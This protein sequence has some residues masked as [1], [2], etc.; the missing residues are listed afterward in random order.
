MYWEELVLNKFDKF[1]FK[2]YVFD[3][4]TN[5]VEL[6]YSLDNEIDFTEVISWNIE[7]VSY[8]PEILERA[9]FALWIMAG[10]SYYK[11]YL[12]KEIVIERGGLTESQ[13]I[14]FSKTYQLG[15]AQFFYTNQL[16]WEGVINFKSD[17][18]ESKN[19]LSTGNSGSLSA[20][21]GGKDSIVAA[22]LMNLMGIEFDCWAVNQAERFV[23]ISESIGAKTFSV[24]RRLDGKLAKLNGVDAYNGHVPI[25]AINSFIGVVLAILAG[26]KSIVWAI[27]SST[28]EPNTSWKGLAVNHQYSKS[29]EFEVDIIEYINTNIASDLEYYS[30]LRPISELRIAEIFCKKFFEKYKTKFSSCNA[31]FNI[32]NNSS[33]KWCGKCPKCAFIFII[34][35]PF[36]EKNKLLELF[37]G[38]DIYSDPDMKGVIEELL[39][40]DGHKPLECVGEIAEVRQ[41]VQMAKNSGH[42]PEAEQ[43]EFDEPNYNYLKYSKNSI[44]SNLEEKLKGILDSI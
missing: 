5:T 29:S 32:G 20:L 28:D 18:V 44:P 37:N 12:P 42:Y 27:E 15:L 22:E 30:I 4:A 13:K 26:K 17:S 33:L 40:V 7:A 35:S 43:F 21:G 25:T 38:K 9:L 41:A 34:F 8:N 14:F 31:N 6:K 19:E 2:D 11:T 16:D 10:V 24:T 1:I 3:P 23:G 36:L 39:G